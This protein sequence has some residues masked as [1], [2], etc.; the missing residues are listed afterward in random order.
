M[1]AAHPPR[2]LP[3]GVPCLTPDCV[4]LSHSRGFCSYCYRRRWRNGDWKRDPAFPSLW[5]RTRKWWRALESDPA[6]FRRACLAARTY[7]PE[8]EPAESWGCPQAWGAGPPGRI[9]RRYR[10]ALPDG[11]EEP[12]A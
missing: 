2:F 3:R 4:R 1:P 6:L 7:R 9:V 10:A 11:A 12:A 8:P 5:R